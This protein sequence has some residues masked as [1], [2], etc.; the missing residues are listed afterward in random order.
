M[1]NNIFIQV[2][3]SI[4][5]TNLFRGRNHSSVVF[6]GIKYTLQIIIRGTQKEYDLVE[7]LHEIFTFKTWSEGVALCAYSGKKKLI[8]NLFIFFATN[9]QLKMAVLGQ[10]F[11][12]NN[13]N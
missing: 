12:F 6:A 2:D 13:Y 4:N 5:K 1:F 3:N 7:G 10:S 9:T 11:I 8:L